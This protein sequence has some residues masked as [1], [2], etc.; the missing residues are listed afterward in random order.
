VTSGSRGLG[1]ER[2]RR[3]GEAEEYDT[4]HRGAVLGTRGSADES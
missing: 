4:M 2:T 3:E 1:R